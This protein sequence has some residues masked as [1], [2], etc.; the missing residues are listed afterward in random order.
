MLKVIPVLDGTPGLTGKA[1]AASRALNLQMALALV[2]EDHVRELTGLKDHEGNEISLVQVASEYQLLPL[3]C[4][5]MN[6]LLGRSN[7][8][9]EA[10]KNSDGPA[11]ITG[12]GKDRPDLS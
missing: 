11:S 9:D 12:S 10:E 4:E 3:G 2:H 1:A 7:L 8:D 5:I 6:E